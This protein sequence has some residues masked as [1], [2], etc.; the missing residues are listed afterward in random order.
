MNKNASKP[1]IQI[2]TLIG[3]E[4]KAAEGQQFGMEF[5]AYYDNWTKKQ[6]MYEDNCTKEYALIWERT[7]QAL[8]NKILS[9][10]DFAKVK[11]NPI[12]LLKAVK[13]HLLNYQENR[14]KVLIIL[15]SIKTMVQTPQKENNT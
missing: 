7:T 12:E 14:Y 11:N 1:K 3:A 13:E 15:D 8:Q 2:S 4:E 9:R 6:H 10:S 5:K